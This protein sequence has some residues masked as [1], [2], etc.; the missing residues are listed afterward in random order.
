M[1][2]HDRRPVALPR[3]ACH[4]E[5]LV[6]CDDCFGIVAE[7][8][9]PVVGSEAGEALVGGG[10]EG[11]VVNPEVVHAGHEMREA[12]GQGV[13]ALHLH[14]GG[15]DAPTVD[16]STPAAVDAPFEGRSHQQ[17][18]HIVG[19]KALHDLVS[20]G[21]RRGGVAVQQHHHVRQVH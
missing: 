3:E 8:Y 9:T 21:G 7:E 1:L 6:H 11:E 19:L 17:E 16:T 20:K 12:G 13:I 14:L 18:H 10:G 4:L 5:I 2:D 15:V